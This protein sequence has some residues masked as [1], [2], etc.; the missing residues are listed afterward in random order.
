M[1]QNL[2]KPPGRTPEVASRTEPIAPNAARATLK[3]RLLQL[4]VRPTRPSPWVGLAVAALLIAVESILVYLLTDGTPENIFGAVFLIGVLIVAMVWGFGLGVV[5][6]LA[7][8]AVYLHFHRLGT[9]ES[10]AAAWVQNWVAITVFLAVALS[11]ASLAGFARARAAEADLRRLQVEASRDAL[12]LLAQQQ[13]ALRRVAT[14][15]AR[16][17]SPPDVFATVTGELAQCLHVGNAWLLRYEAEDIGVVVSVHYEPGMTAMPA[18][19]ERIAL[20]EGD[21]GTVVLRTGRAQRIDNHDDLAGVQAERIRVAGIGSIV[22][23]PVVVDGTLWGAAIVG[24]RGPVPLP[25]DTEAR[26]GDFGDLVATAIA[27]A[28]TR[29]ELQVSRD[30]LRALADQQ[31]A[32]RRV[33]T[34]VAHGVPPAE[35]FSTVALELA[36]VVSVQNSSIWRFEPNGEATLVS[37]WDEPGAKGMPVGRRFSLEGDN[38]AVTV[39][40]TGLPARMDS[41]AAAAGPAAAE[42][43][44]RGLCGGVGVPILVDARLWGAAVVG[45]SRPDPLPPD[46]ESRVAD[47]AE[48]VAAAI[49]NAQAHSEL[50]ASR[51]RIVTAADVARRRIERD[52]HDGAQQRLVS[53]GLDLRTVEACVPSD[54]QPLREQISHLVT[55]VIDISKDLQELSRGIH[56]A[57]LATGGLNPALKTL[58]RRSALPVELVLD[59]DRRLPEPVEVAAYYVVAEALTNAA[60]HAQASTAYVQV[61]AGSAHVD[62]SIRDD[63][64]GGADPT[65]GSGLVGLTDRVEAIG[66]KMTVTSKH[67]SG[68]SLRITIPF[69]AS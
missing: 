8:S 42:I 33:A 13:A 11:T 58:A 35:V 36:R 28:V 50:T 67:G 59:V 15:V 34:L 9:G 30:E 65:K 22:G 55:S 26:I 7:S 48:L 27:N 6:A 40:H 57:V 62:L 10:I 63:G 1:T 25:P 61:D 3:T 44:E 2:S 4:L 47:F 69:E 66:G 45:T 32:L 12:G 37:A 31:A 23:V 64:I 14:M 41:H 16:G 24:S 39:L 52:L 17:A 54:L 20:A 5:T 49:A 51:V 38:I 53:L 43:R 19:G 68:T 46:T 29:A 60:K 21:V 18:A 56:P